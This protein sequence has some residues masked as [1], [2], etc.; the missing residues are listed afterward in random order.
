MRGGRL[1]SPSYQTSQTHPLRAKRHHPL[2]GADTRRRV[3]GMTSTAIILKPRPESGDGVH[4]WVFYAARSLVDA[5][6]S[7]NEA[8]VKI[9]SVI[10]DRPNAT[11]RFY[12]SPVS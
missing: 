9:E 12:S 3:A 10:T 8:K 6:Q 11:E 7:D 2:L 1:A 5:G 4:K